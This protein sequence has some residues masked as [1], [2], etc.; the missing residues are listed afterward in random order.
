MPAAS[1]LRLSATFL[2]LL[3]VSPVAAHEPNALSDMVEKAVLGVVSVSASKVAQEGGEIRPQLPEGSPFEKFFDQFPQKNLPTNRSR[4]LKGTGSGFIIDAAGLVATTSHVVADAD[5]VTVVLADGAELAA[6]IVG[7]DPKTDI[8]V[9]R[10]KPPKPLIALAF[11]DSSKV[12]LAEQVIAIGQPFGL[13]AS[14]SSGIVSGLN[15]NIGAGP[16][17]N[18]IQ[19]DAAINRGNAGGPLLNLAGEVVGMITTSFSPSGGSVGIGFAIPS[20]LVSNIVGKLS[21]SGEVRRGWLGVR[22]QQIT[23]ELAEAL[24]ISDT[25]GALVA[26]AVED[27]PAASFGI[28]QGDVII[29]VNGG[30][31]PSPRDLSRAIADLA[32]GERVTVVV[33]REG[34]RK[35]MSIVLGE[36]PTSSLKKS[37]SAEG[38]TFISGPL[39]ILGMTLEDLSPAVRKTF[40]I[41]SK[42]KNGVAVTTVEPG[43]AAAS[44]RIRP[45]DIITA[46][47]QEPVA[48]TAEVAR[49]LKGR[50]DTATSA[51]LHISD[52]R[53]ERR[54]VGMSLK[55]L[56][57]EPGHALAA[58]KSADRPTKDTVKDLEKLD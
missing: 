20:N 38:Q 24:K 27:G 47:L 58:D 1:L 18:F 15:R 21:K 34:K 50:G 10:V 2:S 39:R 51:L 54:F 12:R 13:S 45:G 37:D 49:I 52:A 53:G 43:G 41:S 32:V 9:L 36:L 7:Q 26:G 5:A 46:I 6:E 22:I 8:A 42:I 44:K 30:T 19:T 14:V 17:D 55:G 35:T 25:S 3:I 29:E 4:P 57:L 33:L 11:G 31:I 23:K 56:S 48:S 40:S 28:K 16:Y